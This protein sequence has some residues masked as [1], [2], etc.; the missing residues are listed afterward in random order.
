LRFSV[1]NLLKACGWLAVWLTLCGVFGQGAPPAWLPQ[2]LAILIPL[3]V[4][5]LPLVA[6][7]CLFGNAEA[8]FFLG[9][10][11]FVMVVLFSPYPAPI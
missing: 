6:I 3:G 1:R 2:F 9:I 11:L 7:G 4:V 5:S 8:G 10:V